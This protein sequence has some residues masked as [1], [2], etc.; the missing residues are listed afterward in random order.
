MVLQEVRMVL[1]EVFSNCCW[2]RRSS[3]RCCPTVG[4]MGGPPGG[5]V[6]LLVGWEIKLVLQEVKLVLQ[7]VRMVLQEVKMVL[8]EVFFD[9]CWDGRSSRRCCPTVVGTG[10]PPGGKHGPPGGVF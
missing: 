8:Q 7:E 9:C 4:G 1:Q 3:R 6:R 5:A 2:D 10:G